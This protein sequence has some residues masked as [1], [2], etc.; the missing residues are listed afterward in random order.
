MAY[1]LSCSFC[2][3][4]CECVWLYLIELYDY[5]QLSLSSF[6]LP[7]F[8]GIFVWFI[9][10][11]ILNILIHVYVVCVVYVCLFMNLP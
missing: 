11:L 10:G 6:V 9:N 4:A 5:F 7:S 8:Y 1:G 2:F 3:C